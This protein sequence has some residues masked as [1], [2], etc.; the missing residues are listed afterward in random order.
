MW[1]MYLW[2]PVLTY[3]AY[4][5]VKKK[6]RIQKLKKTRNSRCIYQDE[7]H[8]ACFEF[9]MTYIDFK[10]LTRRIAS[11]KIL[12]DKAFNIVKKFKI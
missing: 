8:R 5:P 2:L 9:G 7:I 12:R 1:E 10:D 11:N 4:K 3:S 6:E